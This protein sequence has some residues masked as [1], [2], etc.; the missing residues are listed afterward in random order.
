MNADLQLDDGEAL[1]E[2]PVFGRP[3]A[4]LSVTVWVGAAERPAFLDQARWLGEAWGCDVKLAPGRH[5][6]DVIDDLRTPD[7]PMMTR[8]LGT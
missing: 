3:R 2:S 7:S 5:H 8:L 1:A 4:G 6:F